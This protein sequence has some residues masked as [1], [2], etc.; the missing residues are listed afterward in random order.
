MAVYVDNWRQQAR[1]GAVESRW[2]HLIADGDEELHAFAAA[3]G[4]RR[5][6]FQFDQRHPHRGHY[7]V[8]EHV[9]HQAITLGAR[10]VSWR[11]LGAILRARRA[12]AGRA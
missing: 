8:P 5:A 10:P 9:R 11:E 2:S 3:L 4:L 1:L 6:W 7:D 12:G